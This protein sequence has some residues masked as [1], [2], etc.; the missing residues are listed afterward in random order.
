MILLPNPSV[1]GH[2]GCY[3]FLTIVNK[4]ARSTVNKYLGPMP[5]SNTTV[6]C[7]RFISVHFIILHTDF[8]SG[9]TS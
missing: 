6:S 4:T 7:G 1:E 5:R 2:L 8:H 3:H 9:C